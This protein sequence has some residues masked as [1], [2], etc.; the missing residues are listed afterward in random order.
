M[1]RAD[2]LRA[3][4]KVLQAQRDVLAGELDRLNLQPTEPEDGSII[5]FN[6][7]Y[8]GARTA[9]SYAALR[10][11]GFWFVTG[12]VKQSHF[13]WDELLDWLREHGTEFYLVVGS[14]LSRVDLP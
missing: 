13:A 1:T 10:V 11:G 9:Y 7:T 8:T 3:Q 4:L 6:I 14:T 5:R 12:G 2:D